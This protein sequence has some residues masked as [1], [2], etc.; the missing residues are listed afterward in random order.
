MAVPAGAQWRTMSKATHA[1][2]QPE[3]DTLELINAE[4]TDCLARQS[5]LSARIDN[6]AIVLVGYAGAGAAFL[7]TRHVQPVLAALAYAAYAV[8]AGFGIWAYAV[9][10]YYDVPQPKNLYNSFHERPKADV[11]AVL[12]ATRAQAFEINAPKRGR[13]A[14][15]WWVSLVSLIVGVILM[16][17]S[18]GTAAHTV[19]HDRQAGPSRPA[20]GA[21]QPSVSTQA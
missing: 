20:A 10:L 11:L 2:P 14:R 1:R 7:A 17:L 6:K 5:D 8:A 15:R 3:A 19:A 12:A 9:G 21:R 4:I 18:L 16:L 13:K